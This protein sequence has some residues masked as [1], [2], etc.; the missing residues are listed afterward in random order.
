M[1][2]NIAREISLSWK[3][4]DRW[5]IST[6]KSSSVWYDFDQLIPFYNQIVESQFQKLYP[7]L[8]KWNHILSEY[9][10]DPTNENWEKFRP[11]RLSREE[12][13]SDWLAF[14]LENSKTGTFAKHLFKIQNIEALNYSK[15]AY[16]TREEISSNYRSDIIIKW[17]NEIY[18]HIEVKTGDMS[19]SKTFETSESFRNKHSVNKNNWYNYILLMSNQIPDWEKIIEL[20]A[21]SIEIKS[22]TWEDVS[23]SLRKSLFSEESI[24]WKTWAIT[25]IGAIEQLL[26]GFQGYL[27]LHKPREQVEIKIDILEKGLCYES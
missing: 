24:V 7:L 20:T 26:I 15:P 9:G 19:L 5:N 17:K 10:G 4:F 3:I 23:I 1:N 6:K 11:L 8:E 12:D 2:G 21:K 18:T 27:V 16:V 25:F 22:I 13:W 14:L